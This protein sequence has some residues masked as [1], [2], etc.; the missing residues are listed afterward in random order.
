MKRFLKRL[1]IAL[2]IIVILLETGLVLTDNGYVNKVLQLTVL[3]G[4]NE[5]DIYELELFDY[6]IVAIDQPQPWAASVRYN[7]VSPD[8]AAIRTM[9]KL[10][11]TG[12]LVVHR[13]SLLFEKYWENATA[14]TVSN[15][16][17]MAKSIVGILIGCALK[18]GL[19]QSIDQPVSDFI[20][21]F[22]EPSKAGITIRHLL[23][24]SS[25]LDF[26]EDYVSVFSWPAEAYYGPDVNGLTMKGNAVMKPGTVWQYKGG[27]TQL[28]GM[29]LTKVTGMKVSDYASL[30][31]WKPIGAENTAYWSKDEVGNVKVSCCY[32][33]SA[34][35]FAKIGRLYKEY[36]RWGE[37]QI[38]DSAYVVGSITNAPLVDIS[39]KPVV[40][41]GFQWWLMNYKHQNIFYMRGIRGQYVFVIP[42]MDLIVVRLGHLRGEKGSDNI[43]SDVY[44]YLDAAF[45]VAGI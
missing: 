3:R 4:I 13:D 25:G 42:A 34:R 16:F 41:Y 15:S 30:K 11:T 36:G 1:L 28:L 26:K 17:S 43:P 8:A 37:K 23:T 40:K 5:P 38:V 32:Y 29:I 27:D 9:E 44:V 12:F 22:K 14:E 2:G 20:P 45:Q 18:D 7:T 6:D 24:M 35:D 31:L 21:A 39:Q 19:I 10:R 33:A